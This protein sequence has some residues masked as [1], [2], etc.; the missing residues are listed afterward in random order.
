MSTKTETRLWGAGAA[1]RLPGRGMQGMIK[2]AGMDIK[3]LGIGR[4]RYAELEDQT[5][6]APGH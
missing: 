4:R 5:I 1:A 3:M 6:G 2:E